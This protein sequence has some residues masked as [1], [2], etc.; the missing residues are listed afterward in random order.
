MG[1]ILVTG[2]SGFI[3]GHCLLQLL[4]A[5]HTVRT[6]VRSSAREAELR[7]RLAAAACPALDRLSVVTADLATDAGWSA[8]VAGCSHVLHTASPFPEGVPSHEDELIVPAREGTL[9]VLR[10]ARDAGVRRVVVTS[11][12]AAIGYG[13]PPRGRPF[14][15]SDWTD[16]EAAGLTA[17]VKSKT[18][19]ER[20][21]WDFVTQSGAPELAVINPVLV[22]GP[23]LA[24]DYAASIVLVR[25]LLEGNVPGCPRL[26]MGVVDVRDVADL[27]LRAMTS[28]AAAGERFLAAAGPFVGVRDIA[29]VL[30]RRLGPAARRVPIRLLPD[31]LVRLA[32]LADPG[33]RQIVPELGKAKDATADKARRLLGW[34]PRAP[35]EAIVAAAESLLRLGLVKGQRRDHAV[36]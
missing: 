5:G 17:Y 30:R 1:A 20:A 10:A 9:R 23:V 35:E 4:A 14:D 3:A 15:E 31:W 7:A 8:A 18:L 6:T 33:V 36:G 28:P 27:H 13:H 11:S 2:G 32:A 26:Q 24:A 21:A 12:F 19:A 22:L 25:R 34:A 29:L 16:L